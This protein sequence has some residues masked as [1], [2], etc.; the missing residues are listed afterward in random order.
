M[1]RLLGAQ[2]RRDRWQLAIWVGGAGLLAFAAASA[3]GAEFA[4]EADRRG[5]VALAATNPAFM[6][7]RGVPDGIEVGAVVFFTTFAFL[8]VMAGLLSTFLVVR[9]TRADEGLGRIELLGGGAAT[10]TAPL[11]A[12]LLLALLANALLGGAVGVGMLGAG[13]DAARAMLTGLTVAA[14]GLVFA[15]AAAIAAQ[16]L[17]SS[18]GANG[19]SA[20]VVGGAYLIRGAGDAL[21]TPSADLTSAES[22]WLSWLSPIGWGQRVR[23]FGDIDLWPLLL[24]L[25]AAALLAGVALRLRASRDLG[26]S[27]LQERPGR[28]RAGRSL[29]SAGGLA[30][31]LQRPTLLGWAAGAAVLGTMAGAL[32][33]AVADALDSNAALSELIRRL[34]P[35]T[36]GDA[37]DIFTTAILGLAGVLA[38][39]AGVQAMVRLRSE[40]SEDRAE[41]LLAAPLRRWRWML[42]HVAVACLSVG[43]VALCA[44]LAAGIAFSMTGYPE[45]L[46]SSVGAAAAHIPTALVF[47]GLVG[48]IF[49]VLPRLTAPLGWGLLTL[50]IVVGQFGDL[51]QLPQ[52]VQDVSPF[53]HSPGLPADRLE[54]AALVVLATLA[55]LAVALGVAAFRRRDV[56]S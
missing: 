18:R 30:W 38:A 41:L 6:F 47:V 53:A 5:I 32:A 37:L 36:R 35:S 27:L 3:V 13:L 52:A 24:C 22:S 56:R 33:P 46:G 50:G 15:G 11:V 48:V 40:E 45:R 9:H 25:G 1:G 4:A 49:G 43:V 20:A 12:T 28:A 17:P 10:R 14:I 51:L 19:V 2:L 7:L 55:A 54:P 44:G 16:L 29:R 34:S 31:R 42:A 23:P 26:A 21:A 8:G 39:A